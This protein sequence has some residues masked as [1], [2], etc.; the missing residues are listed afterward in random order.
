MSEQFKSMKEGLTQALEFL[1]G[2]TTKDRMKVVEAKQVEP[3]KEYDKE[4]LKQIRLKHNLTQKTFAECFGVSQKTVEAWEAGYNKPSGASVRLFQLLEKDS[5][6]LEEY[7]ILI[8][9]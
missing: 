3:L 6:L 5:N 1:Q 2:D 8:K 9:A 7:E 4:E